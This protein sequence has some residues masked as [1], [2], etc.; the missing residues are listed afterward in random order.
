MPPYSC[1]ATRL[2]VKVASHKS[3][4]E[5]YIPHHTTHHITSYITY[6]NTTSIHIAISQH[7]IT[8][9]TTSH[10][11]HTTPHHIAS[12]HHI[13]HH[14]HHITP[15]HITSHH[16]YHKTTT[17]LNIHDITLHHT[18]NEDCKSSWSARCGNREGL[19]SK[20][21]RHRVPG[22]RGSE[23]ECVIPGAPPA[24]NK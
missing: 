14:L 11:I 4:H 19:T 21:R 13:I 5:H 7:Q 15:H 8:H 9:I 18:T 10:H 23:L 2:L 6:Y 24:T 3:P 20:Q 1:F 12:H 16:T 17:H 22:G